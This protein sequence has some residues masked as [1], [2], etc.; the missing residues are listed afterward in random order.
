MT[1]GTKR[2]TIFDPEAWDLAYIWY[3][4]SWYSN[5]KFI[6]R[7]IIIIRGRGWL[8]YWNG[9]HVFFVFRA[10]AINICWWPANRKL[11]WCYNI[12]MQLHGSCHLYILHS[13]GC[14]TNAL[15]TH[16]VFLHLANPIHVAWHSCT[17]N[18]RQPQHWHGPGPLSLHSYSQNL[19]VNSNVH[20]RL[21]LAP[22]CL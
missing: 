14:F 7:A 20:H 12:A 4:C 5:L 17:V 3:T 13:K 19:W 11:R 22:I 16:W 15:T 10:L 1:R 18:V 9:G 6:K 21:S 2:T 8:V